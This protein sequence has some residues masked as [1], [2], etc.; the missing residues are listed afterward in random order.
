VRSSLA[1]EPKADC[2][3]RNH[4]AAKE[5]APT[6]GSVVAISDSEVRLGLNTFKLFFVAQTGDC[7]VRRL[8]EQA[9]D[10]EEIDEKRKQRFD[11]WLEEMSEKL[12]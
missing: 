4:R 6:A 3:A 12:F 8:P 2:L 10:E 7:I 1:S 11:V 5:A 9:I